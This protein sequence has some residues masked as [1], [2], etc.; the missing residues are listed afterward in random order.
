[1]KEALA[2]KSIADERIKE[3]K[4]LASQLGENS[5]YIDDYY[6]TFTSDNPPS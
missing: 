5:N 3:V 2:M 4:K 1:M 6:L